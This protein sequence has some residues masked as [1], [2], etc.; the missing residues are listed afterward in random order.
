LTFHDTDAGR[1]YAAY[2][3]VYA[4]TALMWLWAVDGVRT[5]S[6]DLAGVGVVLLGMGIIMFQPRRVPC[7]RRPA[8][9]VRMD[10]RTC[11]RRGS[12]VGVTGA[13]MRAAQGAS[14][15]EGSGLQG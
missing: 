9:C 14:L 4:A 1:V 5:T 7:A 13:C 6:W 8:A 12:G 11:C 3:G 2:G 10:D 15:A